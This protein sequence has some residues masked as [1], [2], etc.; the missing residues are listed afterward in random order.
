MFRALEGHHQGDMF[1]GI[2]V[3]HFLSEMFVFVCM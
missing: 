2:Q 1:T 3:E